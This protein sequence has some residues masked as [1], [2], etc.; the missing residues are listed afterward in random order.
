MREYLEKIKRFSD[1]LCTSAKWHNSEKTVG[2]LSTGTANAC[3]YIYEFFCYLS[4][5]QDLN[6]HYELEY[7]SGAGVKENLFPKGPADKEGHPLFYLVDKT[8]KQKI[9][10]V[11]AGT[12]I[13][14][15][16]STKRAPDISF[17]NE[18]ACL[19]LPK[20]SDVKMIYD[21]KRK[22]PDS[23]SKSLGESQFAY[24]AI[25]I[26][27]LGQENANSNMFVFKNFKDFN[28]NC[29][30]TNSKARRGD[31]KQNQ[32]HALKEVENFDDVLDLKKITVIG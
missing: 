32:F 28:G 14:S 17:Q 27:E 25:M 3:D 26:K 6:H 22:R 30:I 2:S 20:Y 10:Q 16:L 4:I 5:L 7:Y 24:F 12:K 9:L 8:S 23:K 1:A 21:T 13:E 19:K 31:S 29:L 15:K 11:C 18:N